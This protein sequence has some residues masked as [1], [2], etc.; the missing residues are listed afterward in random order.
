MEGLRSAVLGAC[1]LSTAVGIVTMLRPKGT[2]TRQ[3]RFLL[4]VLFVLSLAVPLLHLELPDTLDVIETAPARAA[5]ETADAA[6]RQTVL[7]EA[8]QRTAAALVALLE[9]AG[10]RCDRLEADVY[11]GADDRIYCSEVRAEC[12]DMAA[13]CRLLREALGE[14]VTLYV[15]E[16]IG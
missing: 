10:I 5:E 1:M 13:A 12:A 14:E 9:G 15:T 2:M 6:L 16:V 4:S 7:T 8:R 3:I 11:I